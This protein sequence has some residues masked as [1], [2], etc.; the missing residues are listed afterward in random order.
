MQPFTWPG[1][2]DTLHQLTLLFFLLSFAI[3]HSSALFVVGGSNCT[4]ACFSPL[5]FYNTNGSDVSCRDTDYNSTSVGVEFQQ[6]VSCEIQS[7]AIP[8]TGEQSDLGWALC[9]LISSSLE[10]SHPRTDT[11]AKNQTI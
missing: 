5:T 10:A 8:L 4:S 1:C 7:Q 2:N 3:S 9:K 6:C 11:V